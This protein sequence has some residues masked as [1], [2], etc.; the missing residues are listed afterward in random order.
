[1][2]LDFLKSSS[3]YNYIALIGFHE[4]QKTIYGFLNKQEA[5]F[6]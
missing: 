3:L 6:D 5:R 4:A 1:M 2:Y